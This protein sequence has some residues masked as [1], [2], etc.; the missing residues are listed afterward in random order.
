MRVLATNRIPL[1]IIVEI[2]ISRI[3]SGFIDD[4]VGI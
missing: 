3:T 4:R 1:V 2:E